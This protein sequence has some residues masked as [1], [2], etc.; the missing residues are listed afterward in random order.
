MP[1]EAL[2]VILSG[3]LAAGTAAPAADA[4]DPEMLEFLGAFETRDG[5]WLDPLT[6]DDEPAEAPRPRREEKRP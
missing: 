3:V 6:L 1:A 4:P 5:Q 2:A